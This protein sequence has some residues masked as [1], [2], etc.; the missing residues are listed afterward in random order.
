MPPLFT[1]NL[2]VLL[3]ALSTN[4]FY[5]ADAW[6]LGGGVFNGLLSSFPLLENPDLEK[7]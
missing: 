7:L 5:L 3:T 4:I 1:L 6:T 2:V